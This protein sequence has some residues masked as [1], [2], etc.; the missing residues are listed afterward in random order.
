MFTASAATN[1]V[2]IAETAASAS[3]IIFTRLVSDI[4][5]VGLN[6]TAFGERDVSSNVIRFVLQIVAPFKSSSPPLL[7]C[8]LKSDAISDERERACRGDLADEQRGHRSTTPH[9]LETMPRQRPGEHQQQRR[10]GNPRRSA[11]PTPEAR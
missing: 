2:V 6:A 5:S 3:I 8:P 1:R 4:T 10:L 7:S 9:L 11:R